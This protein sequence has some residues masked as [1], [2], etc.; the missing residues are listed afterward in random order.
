METHDCVS[1]VLDSLWDGVVTRAHGGL[2]RVGVG[3][4][5]ERRQKYLRCL[6]RR[7]G[8]A[9]SSSSREVDVDIVAKSG[10]PVANGG[11]V[12]KRGCCQCVEGIGGEV[13][14]VVGG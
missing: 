14:A 10:E 1:R 3:D 7:D 6:G 13:V 12:L 11:D 8:H 2:Q 5:R 4:G 9:K